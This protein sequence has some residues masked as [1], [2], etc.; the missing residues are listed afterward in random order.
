VPL[1]DATI[2]ALAHARL[3]FNA[4]L[5]ESRAQD[6]LCRVAL[7]DGGSALD[8]GCG[9]GELLLRL[10]AG[11]ATGA[12]DGVDTD[13]DALQRGRAAASQRGLADRVRFHEADAA[14]F[15]P[16]AT[17]SVVIAVGASHA[18]GGPHL[19]LQS[20]LNTVVAN[21]RVLF[22]D[23]FW[24][25]SPT[26]DLHRVFGDLPDLA[27]LAEVAAD[28]GFRILHVAES[29]VDEWDSFESDWRSGLE[30][31]ADAEARQL[32]AVRREEYLRGYRGV[33]GFGWL[34][35][36]PE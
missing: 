3:T 5:G 20:I 14:S 12:G 2:S 25:R 17:P 34:V 11:S 36:T 35:L 13:R 8:L 16:S 24:R 7:P 31:S 29:T 4:P 32:A 15:R 21:G 26:E 23:G 6:L 30:L 33:L 22:G 28:A 27:G 1:L 18:W 10:T 9:W 19:A